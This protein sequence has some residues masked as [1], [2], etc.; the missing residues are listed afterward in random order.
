MVGVLAPVPW[1]LKPDAV[2][3]A[4]TEENAAAA[5]GAAPSAATTGV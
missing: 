2:A 5:P 4:T 3:P 1:R